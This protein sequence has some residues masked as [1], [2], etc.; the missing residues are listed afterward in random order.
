M[1]KSRKCLSCDVQLDADNTKVAIKSVSRRM[2]AECRKSRLCRD[3][4]SWRLKDRHN[5]GR[6]SDMSTLHK[7]NYV[8]MTSGLIYNIVSDNL[9]TPRAYLLYYSIY[10]SRWHSIPINY[11]LTQG[12][13]KPSESSCAIMLGTIHLLRTHRRG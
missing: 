7:I 3:K 10:D 2:V 9:L 12:S 4:S 13:I 8:P 5:V 6:P 11:T 1:T